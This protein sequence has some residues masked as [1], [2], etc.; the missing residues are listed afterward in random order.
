MCR[1]AFFS[2]YTLF[3]FFIATVSTAL[4]TL[5]LHDALP[6]LSL[7]DAQLLRAIAASW[8]GPRTV[9]KAGHS[10]TAVS[11]YSAAYAWGSWLRYARTNAAFNESMPAVA[12][13]ADDRTEG[14][15]ARPRM[16]IGRASCRE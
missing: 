7:S 10:N 5:S 6:I 16:Q 14:R 4:Y 9:L 2:L 12:S 8:A 3:L 1:V 15:Q 13:P 11:V